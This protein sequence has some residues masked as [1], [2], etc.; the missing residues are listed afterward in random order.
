MGVGFCL[1]LAGP[2]DKKQHT[3]AV[4]KKLP[5]DSQFV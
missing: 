2:L 5:A 1:G 3:K 4:E